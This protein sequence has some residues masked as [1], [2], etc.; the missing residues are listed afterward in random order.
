MAA[1]NAFALAF[2]ADFDARFAE[3]PRNDFDA[4][5]PLREDE[6]LTLI[7]SAREPRRVTHS[8]TLQY[9]RSM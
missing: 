7:F 2:M 8:L 5:R 6:D 3:P 1:A 9:D 4:N